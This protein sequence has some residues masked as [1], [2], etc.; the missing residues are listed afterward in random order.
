[1]CRLFCIILSTIYLS[2]ILGLIITAIYFIV[3][4]NNA[5]YLTIP[6]CIIGIVLLAYIIANIIIIYK[7]CCCIIKITPI[8]SSSEQITE[9]KDVVIDEK[10]FIVFINPD[11]TI[12]YGV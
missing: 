6:L 12:S 7:K 9:L 4:N 11:N 3:P 2:F 5:N 8:K 1:M 10:N